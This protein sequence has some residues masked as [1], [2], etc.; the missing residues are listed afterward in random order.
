MVECVKFVRVLAED[1]LVTWRGAAGDTIP[2]GLRSSEALG[3]D[4]SGQ[5]GAFMPPDSPS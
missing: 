3:G 1:A 4:M 2:I 5:R